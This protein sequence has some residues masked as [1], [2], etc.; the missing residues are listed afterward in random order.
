[1][2]PLVE[3]PLAEVPAGDAE[4]EVGY[5]LSEWED[6]E[7]GGLIEALIEVGVRHPRR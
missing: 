4:G 6:L 5:D 1:L 7:R 2:Q 3:S